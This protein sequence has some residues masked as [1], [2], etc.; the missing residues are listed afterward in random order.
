MIDRA[1]LRTVF[2]GA[3]YDA[4]RDA[5]ATFL[6]VE[7]SASARSFAANR[8]AKFGGLPQLSGSKIGLVT[9]FTCRPIEPYLTVTEFLAGRRLEPVFVEYGQWYSAVASPGVLDESGLDAV[10]ILLHL[11]DVAPAFAY[12]HL[13]EPE[14]GQS[15]ETLIDG[16]AD[17]LAAFRERSTIPVVLA[18]FTAMHVGPERYFDRRHPVSK[19]AAID[20][21]NKRLSTL[22]DEI[23]NVHILDY[24]NLV[25]DTGRKAWFD[26]AKAHL[27]GAAIGHA[28]LDALSHAI[29]AI[30]S[31][32]TRPRKKV[33][34][35]DLDNTL[36]GG[37]VGEDGP[38]G[39]AVAGAYP[40][41]AYAD[42][43][44]F[45][46][47]LSATGVALAIAS[48]NNWDDALAAFEG[49]PAMPLTFDD[50][51][52]ARINWEEK[53]QNIVEVANELNV[54]TDSI[55]FIDDNPLECGLVR[56]ALP[57]VTVI[58]LEGSPSLFADTVM[59]SGCF[60]TV[61]VTEED[62]KK[63][64]MF[65]AERKRTAMASTTDKNDFLASLNLEMEFRPPNRQEIPRVAQLINKTNQFNLTTRRYTE[66]D[67]DDF[68]RRPDAD[69]RVVKLKDCFGDYGLIGVVISKDNG[70]TD[71]E[72]DSLLMSCR[73]LGRGVESAILANI[74]KEARQDG[75]ALLIGKFV[76]SPK[77][78]QVADLYPKF[79]FDPG[80]EDG[81]FVRPLSGTE[82]FA[83]PSF[84]RVTNGVN[85]A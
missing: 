35:C 2:N 54:G 59:A 72:I 23:G 32:L 41:N 14:S 70:G 16:L 75:K 68:L 7:E 5:L 49:N 51:S 29:T 19:Q 45:L 4:A 21:L 80:R 27:N 47:N 82:P 11:E 13:Q 76:P 50:F 44:R 3:D 56:R 58:Q 20:G 8:I 83:S 28:G 85:N 34:V 67:V 22:A 1:S 64:E 40:G 38:D 52:A 43:Q 31:A 62:A 57:E 60:D 15:L 30:S 73:V 10:F 81:E 24:A 69:I 77:N 79:G 66:A 78:Q 39:I 25:A 36:W 9:S 74:E 17:A 18:T 48:K 71:R 46:K 26:P 61:S 63:V 37:I 42:F 33:L 53:S 65:K 84:I 55:V 12:T 6:K